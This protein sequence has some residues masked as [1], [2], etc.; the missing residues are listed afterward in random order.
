MKLKHACL[1][2]LVV[3]LAGCSVPN[4]NNAGETTAAGS[5]SRFPDNPNEGLT[6]DEENLKDI[7]LAGGCFWGVE[8]YMARVFGV[9]DVTSGYANG[10]TE[11][12]SYEDVTRRNTGHAETVHVRY[13]PERI[14]L[15]K[16]LS[17][18][19]MI[20]DPTLLNQQ[21]NDRG[22]QYRTGVYYKD[23]ADRTIIEA[24]MANEAPKY[25]D[26]L[27]TEVEPLKHYYLAEEYH[28][29]YLEKNPNG[30]CHVEFDSLED[31]EV[32]ALIDS[33]LY[34][35]PSDKELKAT[36]TDAQYQVTQKNDT[37][38]AYSNEYWD[39]YEPGIY[40]DV[41]TGE[42]LFSS[43]DKYDSKCGW[44][45]FTQPIEPDVVTEHKDTSYNM[46]RIEIR[47]RSGDSHLG[48]VFNDGPK[49]KG[50]L[51]YCINSA[52]ILFIPEAEMEAEGYGYL[53]G[54]L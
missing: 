36:L 15:E 21:G 25:D 40:V 41:A 17:H 12:P 48:H 18:Y 26:P 52:S 6:F 2:L 35:K 28:Q 9:Y 8:A 29:D 44:P 47:S 32:P 49:D 19:F 38:T 43:R 24:V 37:E 34:P 31:Q 16:L 3:L 53:K 10:N 42:P 11:N 33:A 20:I 4:F 45:S 30:Y 23:E 7:W 51:R 27:V 54:L 39:N 13:D 22:E 46:V 14:N 50:G 1:L 5:E